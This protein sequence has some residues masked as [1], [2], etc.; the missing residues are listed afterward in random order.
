MSPEEK[1]HYNNFYR[2]EIGDGFVGKTRKTGALIAEV[3]ERTNNVARFAPK[4]HKWV[5]EIKTKPTMK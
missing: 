3:L 4:Q 1:N 5:Q 2:H